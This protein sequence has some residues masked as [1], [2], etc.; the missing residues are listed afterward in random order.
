MVK[1][2]LS[3][4]TIAT[5][6]VRGTQDEEVTLTVYCTGNCEQKKTRYE[7]TMFFK[8]SLVPTIIADRK[9]RNVNSWSVF[10]KVANYVSEIQIPTDDLIFLFPLLLIATNFKSSNIAERHDHKM[11]LTKLN[12]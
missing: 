4:I 10:G 2:V 7:P 3:S 9:G 12:Y 6:K 11:R 8:L 5:I 1:P